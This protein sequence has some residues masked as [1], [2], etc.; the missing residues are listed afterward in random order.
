M[1]AV[2]VECSPLY[3]RIVFVGAGRPV[4]LDLLSVAADDQSS[5]LMSDWE[6][7]NEA[8]E[9][10]RRAWSVDVSFEH[11]AW[12]AVHGQLVEFS[13]DSARLAPNDVRKEEL[14]DHVNDPK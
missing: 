8:A 6:S 7:H 13:L 3:H 9:L 2:T 14:D 12:G 4:E 10:R 5:S 11:V 1:L